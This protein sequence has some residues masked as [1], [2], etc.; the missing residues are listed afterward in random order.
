VNR[1]DLLAALEGYAPAN[2]EE[3]E[4]LA[5]IRRF[6]EAP[7]DPFAR[8][9]PEG[10]VTA[11][12]VIAR[13]DAS[14][15][16]LVHH[17]KLSRWLQPGGHTEASD[18]S[19]FEAAL[20]EAR[21]E[22]GIS[23]FETPLGEA[24]FDV[25]VHAIPA[26]KKDPAHSHFDVRFLLTSTERAH[27]ARAEDP[28]RP[29]RWVSLEAAEALGVDPSLARALGKARRLLSR[30]APLHPRPPAGGEGRGE[31]GDSLVVEEP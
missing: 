26:H 20:R 1:S 5:R 10:H 12:A 28:D 30:D 9:N 4:S 11:S 29:M 27:A 3:V 7:P 18:P 19:A 31:G 6:L 17:R 2:S 13:P 8:D 24:I 21:E 16:L 25:D 14:E 22:T 15:F 23:R